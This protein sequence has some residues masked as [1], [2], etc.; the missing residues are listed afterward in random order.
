MT[1]NGRRA[2]E[3]PTDAQRRYLVRGLDQ[4]GGKLPLFDENGRE[5]ARKTIEACVARGWAEPWFEN[6][7]KHDWLVCKLTPAGYEAVGARAPIDR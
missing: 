2:G 7:L 5:I 6:P 4:P 3:R 1:T